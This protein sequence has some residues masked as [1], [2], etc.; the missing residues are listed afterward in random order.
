MKKALIVVLGTVAALVMA[1]CVRVDFNIEVNKDGTGSLNG[2]YAMSTQYF[3]EDDL[4]S[5]GKEVKHYTFDGK[6]YIGYDLSEEYDDYDEMCEKL[7]TK[8]ESGSAL[9]SDV[10]IEKK[11]GFLSTKYIFDA[12]T[13]PVNS[14]SS[15]MGSSMDS[16]I[17][18][19][20]TLKLPGSVTDVEGGK[21][22]DEGLVEFDYISSGSSKLHAESSV[23]NTLAVILIIGVI[24][25]VLIAVAVVVIII[26]VKSK[27]KPHAPVMATSVEDDIAA[28]TGATP[29]VPVE[30]AEP[31]APSADE[32]TTD[33]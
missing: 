7:K 1:G 15:E 26:V 17:D 21:I 33:V 27:K 29:A 30:P 19:N 13:L 20:I 24:A 12:E 16:L 14:E 18:V 9:F 22:N 31:A 32:G 6:E 8:S 4:A 3:S 28:L 23:I 11:S 5:S 25:F 10:S 2:V